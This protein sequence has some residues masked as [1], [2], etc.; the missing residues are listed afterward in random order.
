VSPWLDPVAHQQG[1]ETRRDRNN[2]VRY[3]GQFLA[4]YSFKG[5]PVFSR[6]GFQ[7][8]K[9]GRVSVPADNLGEVALGQGGAQ[10]ERGL[11]ASPDDPQYLRI[12]AGEVFD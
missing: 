5:N 11:M 10:L 2:D 9:L 1:L 4:L 7:V 3:L 8:C 6:D 12:L